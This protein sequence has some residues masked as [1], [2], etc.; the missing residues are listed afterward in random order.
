MVAL[1]MPNLYLIRGEINM[2]QK[3]KDVFWEGE[4]ID[5]YKFNL[6]DYSIEGL[7]EQHDVLACYK[8]RTYCNGIEEVPETAY[9]SYEHHT[10][11][12]IGH[13]SSLI[14]RCGECGYQ[15]KQYW[16]KRS[17]GVVVSNPDSER[18]PNR[19]SKY[20]NPI[21]YNDNEQWLLDNLDRC[22]ERAE[23]LGEDYMKSSSKLD[24]HEYDYHFG[25]A[26]FSL[27]SHYGEIKGYYPILE[28]VKYYLN[29]EH[30]GIGSAEYP[31]VF[32]AIK[33]GGYRTVYVIGYQTWYSHNRGDDGHMEYEVDEIAVLQE[34]FR[35]GP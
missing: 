18:Y 31:D 9:L 7:L 17:G 25:G 35:G 14:F 3:E 6:E 22:L 19:V 34:V 20:S 2:I 4:A 26:L 8:C 1:F 28:Y 10:N 16:Q 21:H 27:L 11:Y 24:K 33:I 12:M 13:K 29:P 15:E 23:E 32:L 30:D 5:D